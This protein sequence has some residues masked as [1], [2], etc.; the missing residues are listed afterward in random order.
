MLKTH[1]PKQSKNKQYEWFNLPVFAL[2]F[3]SFFL[4]GMLSSSTSLIIWLASLNGLSLLNAQG[5]SPTI[6]HI[7]EMLFGFAA[8]VAVGFI[9]TAVQTWTGQASISG[10]PLVSIVAL[11]MA[12]RTAIWFNSEFSIYLAIS[13]QTLWWLLVITIYSH[14]IFTAKNRRNYLFIPLLCALALINLSILLTDITGDHAIALHL[15]RSTVLL[16]IILMS[17][18][19]GRVIPFFTVKG[20]NTDVIPKLL[21]NAGFSKSRNGYMQGIKFYKWLFHF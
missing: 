19:G 18:V 6:W 14:L 9:L 13:L 15:S 11:W 17:V 5:L 16:F 3:R 7:H 21:G 4:L 8:T 20:A 1:E 10:K 12:V 2:A